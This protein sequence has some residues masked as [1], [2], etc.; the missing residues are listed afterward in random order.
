MLL[1]VVI[2]AW[3]ASGWILHPLSR[4]VTRTI[5]I[6]KLERWWKLETQH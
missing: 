3:I 2:R 5:E 4:L 6:R 1:P